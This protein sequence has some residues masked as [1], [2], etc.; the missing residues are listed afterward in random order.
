MENTDNP[1]ELHVF[2]D[3]SDKAY[4]AA[5]YLHRDMHSSLVIAKSRVAPQKQDITLPRLE[6]MAAL[7]GSRLLRFVFDAFKGKINIEQYIMWSDSQIVLHWLKR[8]KRLPIFVANRVRE[9]NQFPCVIK[10]CPTLDNPA[11]LVT[12]GISD[13][14][15]QQAVIWWN[16]PT[17][18]KQGNWPICKLFDSP[19]HH[20][21][22]ISA[23][24]TPVGI[25][26]VIDADRFSSLNI[27]LRVSALVLRFISRL[28]RDKPQQNG[29]VTS[30]EINYAEHM[31]IKDVQIKKYQDIIESLR[32]KKCTIGPLVKQL[33]LFMNDQGM[34]RCGGR[35]HN[36]PLDMATKFPA[37]LPPHHRSTDLIIMNS[38][39]PQWS[40]IYR[41]TC[42]AEILDPKNST[43]S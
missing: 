31:W 4:G 38:R 34:I 27:L 36:A 21:S 13:N 6:L 16:G 19:V 28:K 1:Y 26:Q 23:K 20:V 32:K 37:L 14:K 35:I 25:S 42:P 10:Y 3:A 5:V 29:H 12:R 8:D 2:V 40:S 30:K 24:S 43:N 39:T 15:L 41:H 11:D 22:P 17:W 9:I 18:L 33:K 7:T